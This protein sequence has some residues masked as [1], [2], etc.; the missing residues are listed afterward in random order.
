MQAEKQYARI[1]MT[2]GH[3]TQPAIFGKD[4]VILYSS[5]KVTQAK[6]QERRKMR[7]DLNSYNND[8]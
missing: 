6:H 8:C 5:E 1:I 3:A 7:E 4:G 2:D